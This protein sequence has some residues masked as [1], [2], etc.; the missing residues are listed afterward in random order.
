MEFGFLM[1][2]YWTVLKKIQN[3]CSSGSDSLVLRYR[4]GKS[5]TF[6]G[7]LSTQERISYFAHYNESTEIP[8]GFL[9]R[10]PISD[11]G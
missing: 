7:N 9:K 3:L 8:C 10:F 5:E 2:D 1:S 11:S 6:G 4:H